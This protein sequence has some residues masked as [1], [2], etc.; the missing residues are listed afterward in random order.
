[1]SFQGSSEEEEEEEE[2]YLELIPQVRA[3][4]ERCI[5]ILEQCKV[6]NEE[7]PI[8]GLHRYTNSLTAELTFIEKVRKKKPR[9]L[10]KKG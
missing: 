9:A 6:W 1:M 7:R 3:L 2:T 10:K 5:F 8:E 4:K